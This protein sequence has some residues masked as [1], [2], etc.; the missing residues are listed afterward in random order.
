MIIKTKRLFLRELRLEDA[1][2]LSNPDSMKYY[3]NIFS[4]KDVLNWIE[5]NIENYR[6]YNHGL[7]AV[8]LKE[9]NQFIGDCGITTQNIDGE[10]L[11]EIGFHII[12]KFC[13]KGYAS[14]ATLACKNYAFDKLGYSEIYSYTNVENLA[15]QKV[16]KNIG[17]H[18]HIQYK[19]NNK[20]HI[21]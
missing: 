10:L 4:H 2:D 19:K 7:W 6:L 16:A 14:E 17:M 3:P 9:T 20:T 12:P 18:V 13:N 5:W 11:P 15:S 21:V 8:I 1:Y